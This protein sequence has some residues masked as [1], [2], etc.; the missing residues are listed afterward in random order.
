MEMEPH[1]M[2]GSTPG[3]STV[4][5]INGD[6]KFPGKKV[7]FNLKRNRNFTACLDHLT[8]SLKPSFGAVRNIFTPQGG[9]KVDRFQELCPEGKYVAAGKTRFKKHRYT[10]I[11]TTPRR[12][13]PF[14]GLDI[15]KK[16]SKFRDVSGKIHKIPTQAVNIKVWPNK[17]VLNRPR[18][19]TLGQKALGDMSKVIEC[20]ND[21]RSIKEELGGCAVR[22]FTRGGTHINDP[23]LL[24]Q[25]ECYVAVRE[26]DRFYGGQY[27]ETT[28]PNFRTS[29]K[30]EKLPPLKLSR[31]SKNGKQWSPDHSHSSYPPSENSYSN[32]YK[33]HQNNRQNRGQYEEDN[34]FPRKPVT[35]KRPAERKKA[36]EVDY[37]KDDG[38]VFKAKQTNR[39]TY[40]AR[41][42][43][44]TRDTRVDLPIDQIPAE[45]VKDEE[46]SS[47]P[48]GDDHT[49]P[50]PSGVELTKLPSDQNTEDAE[51]GEQEEERVR[52]KPNSHSNYN[53]N[54]QTPP[55]H[56]SKDYSNMNGYDDDER[57][58][59]PPR[60]ST[61]PRYGTPR[62]TPTSRKH[63]QDRFS[64]VRSPAQS[65]IG[66]SQEEE[67]AAL[68]IQSHFR[69]HQVRKQ[70]NK[71]E[72]Y[73][74]P[75]TRED[76]DTHKK[77]E[78]RGIDDDVLQREREEAATRIQAHYRGYQ[79]RK[80]KMERRVD[81]VMS[82]GRK[83]VASQLS[84]RQDSDLGQKEARPQ[85]Y[86]QDTGDT[87]TGRC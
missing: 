63:S 66:D 30:I 67:E 79:T 5:Y 86:R 24:R 11:E 52:G 49:A 81:S 37:D 12:R 75:D 59:S 72:D 48:P 43:R 85:P 18:V 40:G 60:Q 45:E 41:E 74:D 76:S 44:D 22:L 21:V 87:E 83:S 1:Y 77:L 14:N 73:K 33:K 35:H 31:G 17:K 69:G 47:H 23:S 62:H 84:Q 61:P 32:R 4:F 57:I 70:M 68:K 19:V 58:S 39:Q 28:A 20:V 6:D 65:P 46:T 53:N 15:P 34:V 9:S 82:A 71:D 55:K 50:V 16:N 2:N 54:N 25:H 29:P 51:D 13:A 78:S 42:V 3:I 8:D 36:Q 64:P 38:G 56:T 7:L 26:H 80:N 27:T 10:D